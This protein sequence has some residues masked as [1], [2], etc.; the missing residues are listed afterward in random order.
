MIR[1]HGVEAYEVLLTESLSVRQKRVE[2]EGQRSRKGRRERS[3]TDLNGAQLGRIEG[4]ME[5]GGCLAQLALRAG[6]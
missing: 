5:A 2:K 6:I 4:A 1:R 3:Q